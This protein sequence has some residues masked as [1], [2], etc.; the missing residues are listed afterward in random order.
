MSAFALRAGKR[1]FMFKIAVLDDNKYDIQSIVAALDRLQ[2]EGIKL[3]VTAYTDGLALIKAFEEGARYHMLVLDMVMET[4]NGIETAKRIRRFDVS[5]PILIVTSTREFAIDG[6]LVNAY[7]YITKPIDTELFLNEVR[8]IISK[9]SEKDDTYFIIN[10]NKGI[11]KLKLDDI[12]YFDSDLHTVTA[13]TVTE[14]Y[15]FRGKL[16]EIEQNYTDKGFF[17]IHK[18]YIVNLKHIKKLSKLSVTLV[19]GEILYLSKLRA[20]ALHEALLDYV[21]KN[22]RRSSS[23]RK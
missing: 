18:S 14:T 22:S 12:L 1:G 2:Q 3:E 5:M 6:Y 19:N 8:E 11:I 15:S 4:I 7:R 13:H 20:A 17:K 16:A 10:K 21:S 23:G 9:V